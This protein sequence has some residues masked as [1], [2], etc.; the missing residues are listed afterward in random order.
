MKNADG[1]T[2][3][4]LNLGKYDSAFLC[5]FKPC[6]LTG[7]ASLNTII[8]TPLGHCPTLFLSIKHKTG[9]HKTPIR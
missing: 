3:T 4:E 7:L 6:S 2:K 9:M 8:V 5:G 1:G